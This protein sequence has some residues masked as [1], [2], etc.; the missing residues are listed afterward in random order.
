MQ[1]CKRNYY[2]E[3]SYPAST[4]S[5]PVNMILQSLVPKQRWSRDLYAKRNVLR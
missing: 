1:M 3:S 2:L 5:F 4:V